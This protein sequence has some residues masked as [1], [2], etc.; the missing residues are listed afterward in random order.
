MA[1]FIS[2]AMT[3]SVFC[4]ASVAA[5]VGDAVQKPNWL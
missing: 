1:R 2:A 5:S 4:L 3:V